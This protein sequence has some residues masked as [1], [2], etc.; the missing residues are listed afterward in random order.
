MSSVADELVVLQ[1]LNSKIEEKIAS[2]LALIDEPEYDSLTAKQKAQV[3][4]FSKSQVV[5]GD[6]EFDLINSDDESTPAIL[7]EIDARRV[8]TPSAQ[9]RRVYGTSHFTYSVMV[10]RENR[11]YATYVQEVIDVVNR[12]EEVFSA[13]TNKRI[14]IGDIVFAI[15]NWQDMKVSGAVIPITTNVNNFDYQVT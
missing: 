11:S 3:Q 7:G 12:I 2:D 14:L 9:G 10:A 5:L 15:F 6:D 1:Y 13:E 4:S 8:T